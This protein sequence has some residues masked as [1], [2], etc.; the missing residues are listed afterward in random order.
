[1][2]TSSDSKDNVN[3]VFLEKKFKSILNFNIIM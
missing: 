1:V 2:E 3:P